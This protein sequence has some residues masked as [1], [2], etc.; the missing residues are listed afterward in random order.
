MPILRRVLFHAVRRIA[1]DARVRAKVQDVFESEVKPRAEAA[2]RQAKPKLDAVKAEL[3]DI[4]READPLESP[5]KFAAKLK[6]RIV[7]RKKRR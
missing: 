4:A 6:Q 5:R 7:D 1:S 3:H 2:W